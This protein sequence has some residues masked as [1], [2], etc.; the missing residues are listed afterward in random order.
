MQPISSII[1]Q[2]PW[3]YLLA[4]RLQMLGIARQCDVYAGMLQFLHGL[5]EGSMLAGRCSFAALK[6]LIS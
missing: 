4:G 2:L 3:F 1:F 5:V 6:R